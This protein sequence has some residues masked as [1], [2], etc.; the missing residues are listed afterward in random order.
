MVRFHPCAQP[1]RDAARSTLRRVR[2]SAPLLA[3]DICLAAPAAAQTTL[4]DD[5]QGDWVKA[6]ATCDA[7][8]RLVVAAD[9]L[10]LVNGDYAEDFGDLSV[11]A[12]YFGPDYTGISTVVVPEISSYEP[13]FIVIFNADE[14][15]GVARVDIYYEPAGAVNPAYADVLATARRRAENFSLDHEP[16]KRCPGADAEAGG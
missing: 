12:A 15:P 10:T 3:A 1:L 16:L 5:L 14:H 4:P 2:R 8:A 7:A 13:P 6:D 11:P 9:R